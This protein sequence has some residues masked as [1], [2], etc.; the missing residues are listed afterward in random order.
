M[1]SKVKLILELVNDIMENEDHET[2]LSLYLRLTELVSNVDLEKK[3][4]Q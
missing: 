4:Y 1:K 3:T 2:K